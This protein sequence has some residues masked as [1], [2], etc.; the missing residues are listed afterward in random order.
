MYEDAINMIKEF[1]GCRLEAYPDPVSGG[2]PWTIGY[3][4]TGPDIK[5]GTVWTQE[6]ADND[7]SQRVNKLE[8][9]VRKIVQTDLP[10]GCFAPLVS[11]AYNLGIERLASS[12]L[13]TF[14]NHR[15]F[16]RAAN[17]FPKWDHVD[18]RVIADLVKRR[19]KERE[20]FVNALQ[21]N[22]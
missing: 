1:E 16:D 14:I 4:A 8:D 20:F 9:R 12:H 18:G 2:D 7:L 11:F 6:Q 17:E 10:E 21:E 5:E 13:L 15:E 19:N 3:G 22:S